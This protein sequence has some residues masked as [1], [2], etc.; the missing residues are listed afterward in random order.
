MAAQSTL[1][2]NPALSTLL[3]A[4]QSSLPV[5][6]L[7]AIIK[8]TDKFNRMTKLGAMQQVN[9]SGADF[10]IILVHMYGLQDMP[11]KLLHQ[12][13]LFMARI[14]I[15]LLD[16]HYMS[17]PGN[18]QFILTCER[19]FD[20]L[21]PEFIAFLING[22]DSKMASH[23]CFH[24]DPSLCMATLWDEFENIRYYPLLAHE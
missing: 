1:Y 15:Q 12:F 21:S 7:A 4:N 6:D 13:L 23:Q 10:R 5:C 14:V 3:F 18:G 17:T 16:G 11:E 22:W 20:I 2:Q 19:A 8:G 24:D 9:G